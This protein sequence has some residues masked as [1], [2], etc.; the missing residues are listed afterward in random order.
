MKH[1][2]SNDTIYEIPESISTDLAEIDC[3]VLII[4]TTSKQNN[5]ANVLLSQIM[6]ALNWKE[7]AD[8]HVLS[9]KSEDS[10][11][12]AAL[13]N[14]SK[15]KTIITFGLSPKQL[16]LQI[17]QKMYAYAKFERYNLL[18]SHSLEEL[19]IQK[20]HKASLW[21]AIKNLKKES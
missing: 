17:T 13:S 15:V 6:G 10:L 21:G 2:Y 1:L 3:P 14:S 16:N 19:L 5:E 8:Y 12:L 7:A 9:I 18:F 4:N 11:S 20:E